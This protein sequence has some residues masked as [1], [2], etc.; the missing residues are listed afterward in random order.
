MSL[1][2]GTESVFGSQ[3]GA[4]SKKKKNTIVAIFSAVFDNR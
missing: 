4:D 3:L 1:T 2:R